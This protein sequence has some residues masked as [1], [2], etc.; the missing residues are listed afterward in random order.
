[1]EQGFDDLDAPVMRLNGLFA[2]APYSPALYE[3]MVP[4]VKG[5]VQAARDLLAE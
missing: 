1:M 4:S 3:P 5:I 2:P